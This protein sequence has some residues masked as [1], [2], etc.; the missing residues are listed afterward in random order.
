VHTTIE[1]RQSDCFSSQEEYHGIS[2]SDSLALHRSIETENWAASACQEYYPVLGQLGAIYNKC[3]LVVLGVFKNSITPTKSYK[4]PKLNR[5]PKH[6]LEFPKSSQILTPQTLMVIAKTLYSVA[7]LKST[8]IF[9]PL[10]D[11]M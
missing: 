2:L 9:C 6:R 4:R 10:V 5:K 1:L 8:V 11:S 7:Y 3:Q